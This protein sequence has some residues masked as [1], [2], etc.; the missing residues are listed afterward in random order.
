MVTA[1]IHTWELPARPQ[2]SAAALV[3]YLGGTSLYFSGF[4]TNNPLVRLFSAVSSLCFWAVMKAS[5]G[6]EGKFL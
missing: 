5:E 3:K 4:Q 1:D 2:S 6:N